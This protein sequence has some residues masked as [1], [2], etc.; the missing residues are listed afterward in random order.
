VLAALRSHR[1]QLTVA[2]DGESLVHSG[3]QRQAVTTDIGLRLV[4]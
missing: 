1:T 4:D 2:V 3:G